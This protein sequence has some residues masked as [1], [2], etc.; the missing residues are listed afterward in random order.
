MDDF[1]NDGMEHDPTSRETINLPTCYTWT[2]V[3]DKYL[4]QCAD[5]LTEGLAYTSFLKMRDRYYSH[6]KVTLAMCSL[7]NIFSSWEHNMLAVEHVIVVW[8]A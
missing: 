8:T 6:V 1:I 5:T 2:L 4:A 3:H 7:A